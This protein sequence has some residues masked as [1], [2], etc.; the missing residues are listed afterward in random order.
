LAFL[1]CTCGICYNMIFREVTLRG[2][3]GSVKPGEHLS[4]NCSTCNSH[5]DLGR[6]GMLETTT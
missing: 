2:V 6:E 4:L 1:S 5:A 3:K